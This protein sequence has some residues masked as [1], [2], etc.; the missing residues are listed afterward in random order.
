MKLNDTEGAPLPEDKTGDKSFD[1]G[2]WG[3]E[4][5]SLS[6]PWCVDL[7]EEYYSHGHHGGAHVLDVSLRDIFQEYLEQHNILDGKDGLLPLA[8]LLMEYANKYIKAYREA[9]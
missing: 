3:D 5:L 9:A 2:L 4:R 6:I 7:G 8:D 1:V